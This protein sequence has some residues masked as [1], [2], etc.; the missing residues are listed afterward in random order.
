MIYMFETIKK[1]VVKSLNKITEN[2]KLK[3]QNHKSIIKTQSIDGW[4][5]FKIFFIHT[6]S[7]W[8]HTCGIYNFK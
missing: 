4:K 1:I 2:W 7:I 8:K 3:T 6:N 5:N